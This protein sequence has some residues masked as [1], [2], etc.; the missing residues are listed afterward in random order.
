MEILA[1]VILG[2]S[3]LLFTI[4]MGALIVMLKEFSSMKTAAILMEAAFKEHK[5]MV[6][7]VQQFVAGGLEAA[8]EQYSNVQDDYLKLINSNNALQEKINK[9]EA[10]RKKPLAPDVTFN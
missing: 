6:D 10:N 2:L 1:L 9:L 8:K 7:S 4:T 5:T 3:G